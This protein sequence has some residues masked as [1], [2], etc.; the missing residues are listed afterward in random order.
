MTEDVGFKGCVHGYDA[1]S[2][3]NLGVVGDLGGTD[4]QLVAEE[5]EVVE[6]FGFHGVAECERTGGAELTFAEFHEFDHGVLDNLGI[7]LELRNLGS[8]A[9]TEE[10]GIGHVAHA[11]LDGEEF[12]RQTAGVYLVDEEATHVG[13]DLLGHLVELG[14]AL[15]AVVGIAVDHACNLGGVNLHCGRADAVAGLV[16]GD[17]AAVG[18]IEGQIHVVQAVDLLGELGIEL[19]DYFLGIFGIGG[20][21]AY[22][23]AEH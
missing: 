21:V 20:H 5:V 9:Q 8:V 10:H 12:F 7:H 15:D 16:D 19:D 3:D 2:A 13:A 17:F 22:T 23:G 1:E 11:A 18:G 14:E 6:H 4:H